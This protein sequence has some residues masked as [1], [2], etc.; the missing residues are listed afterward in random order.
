M[1]SS[2]AVIGSLY[3]DMGNYKKALEYQQRALDIRQALHGDVHPHVALS[4]FRMAEVRRKQGENAQELDLLERA[5]SARDL[6]DDR[7]LEDVRA[8]RCTYAEAL[9]TA[10]REEEAMQQA[11]AAVEELDG[12]KDKEALARARE[13]LEGSGG[14]DPQGS[15]EQR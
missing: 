9:M 7:T 4:F 8:A 11:R 1:A 13:I 2:I 10:G 6:A 15:Q 3:R 12:E 5:L 14:G